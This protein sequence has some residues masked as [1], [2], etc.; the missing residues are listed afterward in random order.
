MKV[1]MI[2]LDKGLVGDKPLGDVVERHKKYG[3]SV[4]RLDIIVLS[5]RGY[6][7]KQ[8]SDRVFA[9]PTN[10]LVKFFYKK[11]AIKKAK[12]WQSR[13]Y[14]LIVT[15]DPFIT[16]KIGLELKKVFKKAK[17][18]VHFH[19]DFWDNPL[20]LKE[21]WYNRFLL[22]ISKTVVPLA[23]AIRVMSEGQRAKLIK[24]GIHPDKIKVISTPINIAQFANFEANATVDQKKLLNNFREQLGTKKMILMVGREDKVKGY[25]VLYKAMRIV[26]RNKGR[27]NVVLWVVGISNVPNDLVHMITGVGGLSSQDLPSYYY[28]SYLTVLPSYSESFGKVLVEANACGRP[29]IATETTGAKEIIQN[30]YN[31]LLVPIGD[32]NALAEKI[33][34]LLDN[35][36][37]AQEMGNNGRELVKERFIDNTFRIVNFWK[38]IV[39]A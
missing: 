15:Q 14:D 28:A 2:S 37:K 3:E 36:D 33:L 7:A 34:Y 31:G 39:K 17:L 10:S 16:A 27:D 1:L 38:E 23:D 18:L 5:K 25:D 19:G 26:E 21:K 20:W 32:A 6:S 13:D 9:R 8:I 11:G 35:P 30:G 29:V 24:L 12:E 4:D 22:R